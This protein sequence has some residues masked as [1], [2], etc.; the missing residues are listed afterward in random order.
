M[1][2]Q[3]TSERAFAIVRLESYARWY[4][5]SRTSGDQDLDCF[6]L[7]GGMAPLGQHQGEIV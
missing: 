5:D 7:V 6:S 3:R 1:T 4:R 2:P